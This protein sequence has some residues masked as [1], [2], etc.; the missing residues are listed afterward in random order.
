VEAVDRKADPAHQP[1][2]PVAQGQ[3]ADAGVP[4]DAARHRETVRLGRGIDLDPG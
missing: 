1:A 3:T 4:D 2:D